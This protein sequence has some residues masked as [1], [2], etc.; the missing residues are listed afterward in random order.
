[1]VAAAGNQAAGSVAYP[2]RAPG[3][4]AVAATTFNGCEADYSNAGSDVDVS[5]P[6]GGVD[7]PNDD[8]PWDAEHCRPDDRGRFIFQQTFTSGIGRFG[9]PGG[10]EGTSMSAPHVSGIAALVIASKVIGRRPNPR[11]VE[12]HLERTA[13]DLGPPGFDTRYGYGLVDAAAALR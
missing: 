13:H 11:A 3:V 12:Q 2:A 8:N 7:S 1:V 9:L 5:A 4:I 10:Y 6:G